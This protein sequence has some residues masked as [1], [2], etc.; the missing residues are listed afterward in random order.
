MLRSVLSGWFFL[1]AACCSVANEPE[2]SQ[3]SKVD[4]YGDAL[5]SHAIARLG[6]TRLQHRGDARD[7]KFTPDGKRLTGWSD[8]RLYVWDAKSGRRIRAEDLHWLFTV[9]G[10]ENMM[11]VTKTEADPLQM[12]RFADPDSMPPPPFPRRPMV[13]GMMAMGEFESAAPV[14]MLYRLSP[15]GHTLVSAPNSKRQGTSTIQTW[16]FEEGKKL[17][18]LQPASRRWP[19]RFPVHSMRFSADGKRL[20][21]HG[22]DKQHRSV[23]QCNLDNRSRAKVMRLSSDAQRLTVAPNGRQFAVVQDA[24]LLVYDFDTPEKPRRYAIPEGETRL[25]SIAWS[26]DAQKIA[27]GGRAKTVWLWDLNS[28]EQPRPVCQLTRWVSSVAISPDQKVLAVSD[29]E[30]IAHFVDLNTGRTLT[31]RRGHT[32]AVYGGA[33]SHD[34]R[35]AATCS[36]DGTTILWDASTG[37]QKLALYSPKETGVPTR[38]VFTHDDRQLAIVRQREVA[39]HDVVSGDVAWEVSFPSKTWNHSLAFSDDGKRFAT[40]VDHQPTVFEVGIGKLCQFDLAVNIATISPDGRILAAANQTEMAA[41]TKITLW[42]IQSRKVIR[43]LRPEKGNASSVRFSPDGK[44]LVMSGHSTVRGWVDNNRDISSKDVEDSV[45]LWD[46]QTGKVLRKFAWP[47]FTMETR[48]AYD[49]VLSPDAKYLITA[50]RFG[51]V[52]IYETATGRLLKS[53]TAHEGTVSSVSLSA[54]GGRL[55]TVSHDLTGLVWD[56]RSLVRTP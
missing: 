48:V 46:L 2:R 49:A 41:S 29:N 12:W 27:A 50:E 23:M 47:G 15:D 19:A 43:S 16:H 34:G 31:E 9:E 1:F 35:L 56:F 54:N 13:G 20:V 55:L 38:C 37:K 44:T 14:S 5:P 6:T 21:V 25:S 51:S 8:D 26:P 24:S 53:L 18:E 45:I 7:L 28:D 17:S 52:L 10:P 4:L 11:L 40:V 36:Q 39:F 3:T 32:G 42:D 30:H 33:L 22:A